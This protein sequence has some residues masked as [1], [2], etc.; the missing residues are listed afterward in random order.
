MSWSSTLPGGRYSTMGF[1]LRAASGGDARRFGI[2]LPFLV[3]LAACQTK[4]PAIPPPLTQE[5][6]LIVYLQPVPDVVHR[7]RFALGAA[8][9]AKDD[10]VLPIPLL[11]PEIQPS[12]L[13]RQRL[14]SSAALPPGEYSGLSLTILNASLTGEQGEAA[15][16][17][18]AD[19]LHVELPFRIARRRATV[20]WLVFRPA[21]SVRE[22]FRFVPSFAL[23]EPSK[24]VLALTGYVTNTASNDITVFDKRLRQVVGA[25]VTGR[26][27]KGMVLDRRARQAYAALSAEDA[28]EVI[29]VKATSVVSRIPLNTGDEP[30][31]LALTPDGRTL[32]ATNAGSDTVSFIDPSSLTELSRVQVGEGPTAILLDPAGRRAYVLNTLSSSVSVLDVASGAVVATLAVEQSPQ[33]ADFNRRGDRLYVVHAW[34]PY[35]VLLDPLSL[36]TRERFFI[37]MGMTSVEVHPRTDLIYLALRDTP[38]VQET[39]PFSLTPIPSFPVNGTVRNMTI[40]EEENNLLLVVPERRAL[41]LVDLTARKVLSDIDVGEDPYWVAVMGER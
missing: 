25:I 29:D 33:R 27:P 14:L 37:G 16:Q 7:L 22:G 15:L 4:I 6:K 38:T 2:L 36:A 34:S 41:R 20:L 28:I 8:G 13:D 26:G 31:E 5:G 18:S 35:L 1:L 21:E 9:A 12:Q 32:I 39:D 10:S 3:V 40:D 17:V 11:L 24:P 19:P 23:F 30:Q